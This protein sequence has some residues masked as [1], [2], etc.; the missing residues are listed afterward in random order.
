MFLFLSKDCFLCHLIEKLLE[1]KNG[2]GSFKKIYVQ[3]NKDT[4]QYDG[5]INKITKEDCP[6]TRVPT[7]FIPETK[8]IVVGEQILEG[9]LNGNWIN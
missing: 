4:R 8:E 2:A 3:F 9:M 5:V 7:L 1:E 6:I